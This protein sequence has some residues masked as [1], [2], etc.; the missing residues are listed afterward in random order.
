MTK[1]QQQMHDYIL[2]ITLEDKKTEVEAL[3]AAN[4]KKEDDKTIQKADAIAL[5][6]TL[7]PL[8]NPK[9]ANE[10][11]MLLAVMQTKK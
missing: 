1:A 4:F 2:S 10:I 8:V 7:I 9:N 3:L 5:F 11:K 6:E